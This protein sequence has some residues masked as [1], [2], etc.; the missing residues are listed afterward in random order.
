MQISEELWQEIIAETKAKL[1][2]FEANCI[3]D[4]LKDR[5]V[6]RVERFTDRTGGE[7]EMLLTEQKPSM[8]GPPHIVVRS[9]ATG[10]MHRATRKRTGKGRFQ[11]SWKSSDPKSW[12]K[13]AGKPAAVWVKE[14]KLTDFMVIRG[15]A[16]T[17]VRSEVMER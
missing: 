5:F 7:V 6:V 16:M 1:A 2:D 11:I 15:V 14:L 8:Y 4:G 3:A 10:E 12:A 17:G 13:L 9:V